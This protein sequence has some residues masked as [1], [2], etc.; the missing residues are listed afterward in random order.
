VVDWRWLIHVSCLAP[1]MTVASWTRLLLDSSGVLHCEKFLSPFFGRE[2][3]VLTVCINASVCANVLY[4]WI[5]STTDN[6]EGC[7]PLRCLHAE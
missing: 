7:V 5:N 4:H 1:G 2:P 6:C 3:V